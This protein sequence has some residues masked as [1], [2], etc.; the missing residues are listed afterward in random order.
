MSSHHAYDVWQWIVKQQSL[1]NMYDVVQ[2]PASVFTV[3]FIK[4]TLNKSVY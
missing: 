1:G 2:G 4:N 3:K